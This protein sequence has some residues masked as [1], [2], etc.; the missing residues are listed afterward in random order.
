M[1]RLGKKRKLNKL[2][3]LNKYTVAFFLTQKL[4]QVHKGE[5]NN[6]LVEQY[7]KDKLELLS[8]IGIKDSWTR[9]IITISDYEKMIEDFCSNE[10]VL[11]ES[12][13][14]VWELKNWKRRQFTKAD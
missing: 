4:K 9:E 14:A 10:S 6:D 7:I 5:I 1:M 13:L 2:N 3:I 11:N 8:N 12:S